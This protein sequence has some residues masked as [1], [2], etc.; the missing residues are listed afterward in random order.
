MF[1]S[2]RPYFSYLS[3]V[4]STPHVCARHSSR[5]ARAQLREPETQWC[6]G[7][8][9]V[10]DDDRKRRRKN[11]NEEKR[12][13]ARSPLAPVKFRNLSNS[14]SFCVCHADHV[15][16]CASLL[17]R[18]YYASSFLRSPRAPG[19]WNYCNFIRDGVWGVSCY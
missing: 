6:G 5:P 4:P 9:V 17:P 3:P 1:T 14:A 19:T 8:R 10:G 12:N 16:Q 18:A 7:C 2:A 15:V 13:R 11:G